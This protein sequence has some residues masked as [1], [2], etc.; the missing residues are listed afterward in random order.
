MPDLGQILTDRRVEEIK[1]KLERIYNEAAKDLRDKAKE[2]TNKHK[3]RDIHMRATLS[4]E[5]YRKW[6]QGQVFIGKQWLSKVRQM[7]R[8]MVDVEKIAVQIVNGEQI[9]CFVDNANFIEFSVDKDLGFGLNFGLYDPDTVSLLVDEDPEL[10][11]RRYVDGKACEAWNV[12]TISNCVTQGILQGETINQIANRI[13]RD[14][15][16]T[17]MKAMVRYARTAM[18][19]AQ[20]SGRIQGMKATLK[21]G[22][23]VKKVWL[24][25]S[26]ERTREAHELLD[27]QEQEVD[28]PFDSILGE[29]M[30]PG[31]PNASDE[32]VWNCRC[33][34]GYEYPDRA[35]SAGMYGDEY[36]EEYDEWVEDHEAA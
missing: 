25:V 13:A 19:C 10:L 12:K 15:A 6:Q 30:F 35:E 17:D 1:E 24:A 32:N 16:S 33:A 7:A 18:T 5:D 36:E 29:I 31:D 3:E 2:F 26:D 11:R 34:L 23:Y 21:Q 22:I 27:G 4:K 28:K 9:G 20:N 14:T 8:A